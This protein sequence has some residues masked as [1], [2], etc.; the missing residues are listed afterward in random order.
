MKNAFLLGEDSKKRYEAIYSI[1]ASVDEVEEDDRELVARFILLVM[2]YIIDTMNSRLWTESYLATFICMAFITREKDGVK[3]SPFKDAIYG[4]YRIAPYK[5]YLVDA[6]ELLDKI[7]D[8]IVI[9]AL[10]VIKWDAENNCDNEFEKNK[11]LSKIPDRSRI[12]AEPE[13]QWRV[14]MNHVMDMDTMQSREVYIRISV[15][16]YK[17]ESQSLADA[18]KIFNLIYGIY[19]YLITRRPLVEHTYENV[20]KLM[21]ASKRINKL[22]SSP[23]SKIIDSEYLRSGDDETIRNIREALRTIN[24]NDVDDAIDFIRWEILKMNPVDKDEILGYTTI[25]SAFNDTKIFMKHQE[26]NKKGKGLSDIDEVNRINYQNFAENYTP[27][28]IKAYLD[29][30]IIGQD[31]AKKNVSSAVYNHLLRGLYPDKNLNKSNVLL[32]GP[33]GCG[34]TEIVRRLKEM[35][36]EENIDIPIVISDFSGIVATPWKGRNK[37]EVLSRLFD[38]AGKDIA[39]AQ[40]GIVFLDEFDKI[41]PAVAGGA[42]GYDY[43]NELQG[44]MLGMLEG[45][46]CQ[47]KVTLNEGG[48]ETTTNLLMQ[49]DNILFILAGAF[50]GLDD[51]IRRNER[52]HASS[53]FGMVSIKKV[54]IEYN[55]DN[56]SIENLMGYG[57]RAELAGRIGYVSVLNQLGKEDMIKILKEA[58]D[59]IISKYQN[60]MFA[61][62]G[63]TLEFTED[64]YSALADKVKEFNIGARGLNAILH[65]VLSDVMFKAPS[66]PAIDKVIITGDKVLG[67]GDA[68]YVTRENLCE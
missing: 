59:N 1:V 12:G 60:A 41:I 47:V 45:T 35:F 62:D 32:I 53:T 57:F 54:P 39:K 19:Y 25:M 52:E 64:A 65:D 38:E 7:N 56:V 67:K 66:M 49:T 10:G 34:K 23:F 44:Q 17:K 50:D 43:N 16:T 36:K 30:Y 21:G 61:E 46:S 27:D 28:K 63:I 22:V 11:T 24:N 4:L 42:R 37:E 5:E 2:E 29:E 13:R 3:H 26:S 14:L 20:I 55:D 40:R 9:K 68:I 51:I 6:V 15:N 48:R 33:S 58:K 18:N 8:E 31:S